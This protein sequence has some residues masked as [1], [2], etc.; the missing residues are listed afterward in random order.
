MKI[1]MDLMTYNYL[2][3]WVRCSGR[4]LNAF[5]YKGASCYFKYLVF[6]DKIVPER[7]A[8]ITIEIMYM[9]GHWHL[10]FSM[11]FHFWIILNFLPQKG[12]NFMSWKVGTVLNHTQILLGSSIYSHLQNHNNNSNTDGLAFRILIFNS[13]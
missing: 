6:Y 8:T 9:N 7:L 3:N 4:S 12:Q 10:L 13:S 5:L 11:C 2:D 1:N